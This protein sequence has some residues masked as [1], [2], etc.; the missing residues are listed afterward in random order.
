[1]TAMAE[2]ISPTE[3]QLAWQRLGLGVFA[4]FGVNTYFAKE[5]SD[6]SLPASSF[7]PV[8]FDADSLIRQVKSWG[9][10]YFVLTAK[11]HDGFCLWPTQT[12]SYSVQSSPWREGTGDVV[13]EIA[14]A[15]QRH[16]IGL[17]LYLSPWDRN[18]EHY[19]DEDAYNTFYLAQLLEL[20][21]QYGPLMELWFDGAGSEGRSYDWAAIA[22]LIDE[23][24][25]DAMVFNMGRPTIRWVGNEDGLASDPVEY[26]VNHTKM[27]NYTVVTAEFSEALYLP[28]ECDVSIR[29]G[30]FW[31]ENDA[32]K[33]LEHLLGIYYRS[34]GLG[35]GLLLN[36]PPNDRGTFDP[37]DAARMVELRTAL[38]VLP[39]QVV[40][41]VA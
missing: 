33:S 38:D 22:S 37:E 9:A 3:N 39:T 40:C 12:T 15:C 32:P 20:C 2:P 29:R 31:R 8:D 10:K 25:P 30:W 1:M 36:V 41:S 23:H 26:V 6:G 34:V 17:G 35:A 19:S 14:A 5:W 11:H 16:G 21:T 13:G 7:N 27:S 18:S 24:Q 28:P 4:H